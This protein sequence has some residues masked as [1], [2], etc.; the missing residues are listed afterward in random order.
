MWQ[1]DQ[2]YHRKFME[3]VTT[4]DKLIN[5]QQMAQQNHKR[6]NKINSCQSQ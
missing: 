1:K 3:N 2:Q 4:K 6:T 5:D